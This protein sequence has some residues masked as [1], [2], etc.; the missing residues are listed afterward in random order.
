MK[1]TIAVYWIITTMDGVPLL[2]NDG[3]IMQFQDT[4]SC[5]D[6]TKHYTY[7]SKTRHHSRW[8]T[9]DQFFKAKKEFLTEDHISM[10]TLWWKWDH[11]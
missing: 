6:N 2:K 1:N 11:N 9:K 4:K 7:T 10:A 8:L 5:R 3:T